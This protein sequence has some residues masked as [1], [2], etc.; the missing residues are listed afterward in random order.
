MRDAGTLRPVSRQIG[1]SAWL[2]LLLRALSGLARRGA[3]GRLAENTSPGHGQ[4]P[5]TAP[6][7]KD[8]PTP[9]SVSEAT[10][11]LGSEGDGTVAASRSHS[12]SLA[13][14]PAKDTCLEREPQQGRPPLADA[15]VVPEPDAGERADTAVVLPLVIGDAADLSPQ[16][17]CVA[18]HPAEV[19]DPAA[20]VG[21]AVENALLPHPAVPQVSVRDGPVREVLLAEAWTKESP[22]A[23]DQRPSDPQLIEAPPAEPARHD[24]DVLIGESA[25]T[26]TED[27][28]GEAIEVDDPLVDEAAAEGQAAA[29]APRAPGRYRPRLKEKARRA[30]PPPAAERRPSADRA[31]TSA[32]LE[33]D[34][35]LTFRPGGWGMD[36][37]LLLRRPEGMPE[38]IAIMFGGESLELPAIDDSL[39]EPAQLADPGTALSLGIAAESGGPGGR[40]WVRTGRRLHVFTERAGVFG[41][42]SVPR[43]V[44]GQENVILCA[45]DLADRVLE[46]CASTG[47]DA[48]REAAGPGLPG[49]WRCF[50]GYWPRH[51]GSWADDDIYLAL[52]PLPD[53]AIEFTG[54]VATSR[55]AW[56]AGRPPFIRILGALPAPGEVTID[57]QPAISSADGQW[58]GPGWDRPGAHAVRYAGLLRRYEIVQAEEDW[59]WWPAHAGP[60]L[61]LAG[62]FASLDG[63]K[64]PAT[65]LEDQSAWLLGAR[66]GEIVRMAAQPGAAGAAASPAFKPVWAVPPKTRRRP[67]PRLLDFAA[68]PQAS[69]LGVSAEAIRQ[70]RQIIRDASDIPYGGEAAT[71]ELWLAYK[72]AGRSLRRRSR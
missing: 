36:V 30:P 59:G 15:V 34:L 65:V 8:P 24:A 57:S 63:G 12:D 31:P 26:I 28:A 23:A 3:R 62:A 9:D 40:R 14:H 11:T 20:D 19:D 46:L 21:G 25:P 10:G 44:I 7:P 47:S 39:F 52:S 71:A 48:P 32:A 33:A 56:I 41:F 17:H 55:S 35:V 2:G 61:V 50:R 49:G 68:A 69:T 5:E 64:H 43:V 66:P 6:S 1:L 13:P 22:G 27:Q 67:A 45:G 16:P 53:A 29:P 37:S 54:G 4:E 72:V 58:T 18:P 51:P 70:W 42:T 38:Q 60:R